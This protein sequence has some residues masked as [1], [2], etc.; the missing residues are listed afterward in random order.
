MFIAGIAL[1]ILSMLTWHFQKARV[2][3]SNRNNDIYNVD[4]TTCRNE[5]AGYKFQY[6]ANWS[7]YGDASWNKNTPVIMATSSCEG[8]NLLVSNDEKSSFSIESQY[9]RL[10]THKLS[11]SDTESWAILGDVLPSP[12]PGSE[13]GLKTKDGYPLHKLRANFAND[14]SNDYVIIKNENIYHIITNKKMASTTFRHM[15]ETWQGL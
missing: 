10:S 13:Y 4:V 9:I 7:V 6:P 14:V 11:L 1:I 3:E 15:I 12:L 5:K 2:D 8:L